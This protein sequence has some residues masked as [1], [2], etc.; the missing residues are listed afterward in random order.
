MIVTVLLHTVVTHWWILLV[1]FL[2]L[3][4]EVQ[5]VPQHDLPREAFL[6]DGQWQIA[7]HVKRVW[8]VGAHWALQ[9]ASQLA[10]EQVC[11]RENISG[12]LEKSPQNWLNVLSSPTT[13]LSS[14]SKCFFHMAAASSEILIQDM[15]GGEEREENVFIRVSRTG[16]FPH[17]QTYLNL[18]Y[19]GSESFT[20]RW[21]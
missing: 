7:E 3:R 1:Q 16:C 20:G 8:V 4:E 2:L 18:V 14:L 11:V 5:A 10:W 17:K 19:F 13:L 6:R 15:R 9:G 12:C 21:I